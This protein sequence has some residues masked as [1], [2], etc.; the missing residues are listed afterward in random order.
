MV[1]TTCVTLS[2]L[3]NDAFQLKQHEQHNALKATVKNET[4][5]VQKHIPYRNI[6]LNFADKTTST[7]TVL[8]DNNVS[9]CTQIRNEPPEALIEWLTYYRLVYNVSGVCIIDD[10][11]TIDYS[12]IFHSFSVSSVP[13]RNDRN[14]NFDYVQSVLE[15]NVTINMHESL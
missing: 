3:P 1:A 6:T 10:A 12:E 5:S 13:S 14:Q 4:Y 8:V 7:S 11:S 15:Y 9:L 2:T